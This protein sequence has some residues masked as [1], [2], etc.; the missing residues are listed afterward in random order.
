MQLALSLLDLAAASGGASW[1]WAQYNGQ[2]F[3]LVPELKWP[4]LMPP[5]GT[6]AVHVVNGVAVDAGKHAA[7]RAAPKQ[8]HE[9]A[10]PPPAHACM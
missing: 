7:A 1:S 2:P 8:A 4:A 10:R 9:L 6:L 5:T 3:K